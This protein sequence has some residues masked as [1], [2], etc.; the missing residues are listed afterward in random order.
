MVNDHGEIVD[1][2][3]KIFSSTVLEKKKELKESSKLL[4]GIK[5]SN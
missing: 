4:E 1:S 5:K 3:Q 2:S